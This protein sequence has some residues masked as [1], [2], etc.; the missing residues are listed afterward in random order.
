MEGTGYKGTFHDG[1]LQINNTTW[2]LDAINP[3]SAGERYNFKFW[4]SNLTETEYEVE[5]DWR[6]FT[7][8]LT[9]EDYFEGMN[10]T[11]SPISTYTATKKGDEFQTKW[12]QTQKCIVDGSWKAI[13]AKSDTEFNEIVNQMI[14]DANAYYYQEC[15]EWSIQEAA[16][17]KAAEDA[18]K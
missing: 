6:D 18:L 4:A 17:R 14:K 8:C 3:D 12:D 16:L 10:Y 15:V 13:Y 2:D 5:Q 11:V 7:G 1:M 9:A